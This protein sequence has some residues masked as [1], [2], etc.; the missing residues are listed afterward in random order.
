MK[1]DPASRSP[2]HKTETPLADRGDRR[3]VLSPIGD[4]GT[5]IYQP[6]MRRVDQVFGF[7]VE[8][9][10]LLQDLEFAL[11]E[12]RGQYHSTLILNK[13][14]ETAPSHTVKV[15][16]ITRVDLFIPILTHVYGE[17]QLGGKACIISTYRLDE[18]APFAGR[19][20][21]LHERVVKE[22]VHELGHTFKLRHCRDRS[23]IMHYCRSI[24]D[25]DRKSDQFCRYCKT[26]LNDELKRL[27]EK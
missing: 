21:P 15:L 24:A 18:R 11:D 23:C 10:P 4:F 8:K 1:K 3:I 12:E 22:A 14:S 25:V 7:R 17:A 16:A 6:V 2:I 20:V 26:L 13:L 27:M 5:D 19:E 9:Q